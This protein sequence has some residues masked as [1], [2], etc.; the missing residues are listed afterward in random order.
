M[1]ILSG[2][3]VRDGVKKQMQEKVASLSSVPELAIIQIGN[4]PESTTYIGQKKKFGLSIGVAV[5]HIECGEQVSENEILG[6]IETLN[7]NKNISGIIM[8]LPI[9]AHLHKQKILDSIALEKDVDGLGTGQMGLLHS[10][11]ERALVPATARGVMSLLD[12]YSIELLGKHV[13]VVGRSNLVGK[14]IATLCLKRNATVTV[15]HSHTRLLAD[16]TKT[17]D[18][19]IVACGVTKY[20]TDAYVREGQIVVD[21]GIH[22]T[23]GGMC[24]DVDFESV[25]TIV[26]AISPVPGGVGPLTVLSLFQNVIDAYIERHK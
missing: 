5:R 16:I 3:I 9:P 4:N 15:C 18:I 14:P 22:K 12:Y 26:S 7:A 1:I 21:V 17:A 23:M 2:K 11:S 13:V 10:G 25:S 8:Q 24:G 6:I 20:I 19:L